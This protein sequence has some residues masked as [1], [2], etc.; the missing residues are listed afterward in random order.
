MNKLTLTKYFRALNDYLPLVLF[1]VLYKLDG[2][3]T[4]TIGFVSSTA[5]L[6]LI[7]YLA[8]IAINKLNILSLIIILSTGG[9]T[10]ISGDTSF[11]QMKPTIAYLVF[12]S[13]LYVDLK[14]QKKWFYQAFAEKF[15]LPENTSNLLA[16]RFIYLFV[17]LAGLNELIWRNCDMETWVTFKVFGFLTITSLFIISQF[18]LLKKHL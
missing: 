9:L 3:M 6:S 10:I 16:K 14:K 17:S 18:P 13:L 5:A 8:G 4:A 15:K 12:A 2:I 11:I 1:F 7:S